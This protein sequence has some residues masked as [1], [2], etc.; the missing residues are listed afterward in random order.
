VPAIPA[1]GRQEEE[2]SEFKASLGYIGVAGQ[3]E[4]CSGTLFHQ[5]QNRIKQTQLKKQNPNIYICVFVIP[6][7]IF[8]RLTSS[9]DHMVTGF[10]CISAK[11]LENY[12][13]KQD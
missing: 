13:T 7:L 3:S 2:D 10:F 8:N 12:R 1:L 11:E 4:L 9:P 5:S 6:S